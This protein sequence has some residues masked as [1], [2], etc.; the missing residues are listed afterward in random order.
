M[1]EIQS[2]SLKNNICY[3][4]KTTTDT[5]YPIR[6]GIITDEVCRDCIDKHN[7]N[8]IIDG[9]IYVIYACLQ[10]KKDTEKTRIIYVA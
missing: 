8:K 10:L 3:L 7:S 5:M 6:I 9:N 1:R 2:L 4:C